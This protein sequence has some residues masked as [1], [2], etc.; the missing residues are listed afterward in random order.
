M[1]LQSSRRTVTVVA[2]IAALTITGTIPAV[3][4]SPDPSNAAPAASIVPDGLYQRILDKGVIR[5]SIE[6]NYAPYSFQNADGSYGGF[7]VD[8]ATEIAERLG[9]DV[10]FEVPSFDLVVAGS[11]NDRWDMSVGSVTITAPRKEVL[12]FTRPYAYNPA[13]IAV[14]T[15]SGITSLD[16]LAGQPICV[17]AAT[18]YQQWIEGTLVLVDAPEPAPVPA[19]A[20]AFPLETDQLCAQSVQS[21]RPEFQAWLSSSEAVAAAIA[22]GTPMVALGDPVFY[23]SLGVGFDNTVEDNESL[24]AAVDAIIGQMRDDGTLL[25]LSQQ[26]FNGLDL[27][28]GQ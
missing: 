21:G 1:R 4:Q 3:G 10:A 23:E 17:G 11:W 20:T 6:L 25:A 19:G 24:V 26:W 13:Q 2:S 7:N 22:A 14:T 15:A 16:G 18:T 9:V 28:S 5:T 8:V 12:D 27:V